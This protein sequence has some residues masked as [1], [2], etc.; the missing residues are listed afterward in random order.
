VTGGAEPLRRANSTTISSRE[1]SLNALGFSGS[2]MAPHQIMAWPPLSSPKI[3][4][5][6]L[7][8][9]M[10]R[11]FVSTCLMWLFVS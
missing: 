7:L 11:Q 3:R 8:K 1:S 4:A 6:T 2:L 9:V 10:R 5:Y